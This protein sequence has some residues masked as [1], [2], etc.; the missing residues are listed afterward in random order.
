MRCYHLNNFY[1]AGIHAGIQSAH[2]QHEMAIKYLAPYRSSGY[3]EAALSYMEW[4]EQHKTIIVLNGGM[5]IQL[6]SMLELLD[7]EPHHY[8]Y[9]PFCE[10]KEALNGALTNIA[11]VL[12]ERMYKFARDIVSAVRGGRDGLIVDTYGLR[13]MLVPV[14]NGFTVQFIEKVGGEWVGG[15]TRDDLVWEYSHFDIKLM[16]KF[17]Y[18][19]LM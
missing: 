1:L 17:C 7:S 18:C 16:E 10:S 4:A 19:S 13:L 9:A 2:A 8:A 11:L 15:L 3:E 14:P 12:P 5:E 6:K